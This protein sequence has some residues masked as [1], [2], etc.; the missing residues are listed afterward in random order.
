MACVYLTVGLT[1]YPIRPFRVKRLS[2]VK[3]VDVDVFTYI[4]TG[5]R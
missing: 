3:Y 1:D 4:V 5:V 2:L